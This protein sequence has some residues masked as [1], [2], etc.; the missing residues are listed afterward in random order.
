MSKLSKI[1]IASC[2]TG[3]SESLPIIIPTIVI[4]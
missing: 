2:I 1:A 4:C 3:R